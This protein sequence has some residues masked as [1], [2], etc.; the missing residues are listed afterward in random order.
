VNEFSAAK[1]FYPLVL[2]LSPRR[3]SNHE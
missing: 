3:V 1:L 2:V